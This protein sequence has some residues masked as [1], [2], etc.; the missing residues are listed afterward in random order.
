MESDSL[1]P[2]SLKEEGDKAYSFITKHGITYH[3]YFLDYSVYHPEFKNVYA[4]NIDVDDNK[5]HPIDIQIALTIVEILRI[6]FESNSNAMIMI[7]D[8]LDG[9][10]IKRK[11]LFDRW[12]SKYNNGSILK[13]D[14]SAEDSGVTL[15]VSLYIKKTN[16]NVARIVKAFYELVMNNLYPL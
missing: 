7:C 12:F 16:T 8:T 15:F 10:E 9:K 13:Y 1:C 14:A 4:F 3:A 2:Y 5:P 11:K 6:F